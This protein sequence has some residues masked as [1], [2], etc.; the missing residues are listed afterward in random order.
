MDVDGDEDDELEEDGEEET[1]D[2][3]EF[4]TATCGTEET[5][6]IADEIGKEIAEMSE[7]VVSTA[8]ANM[9]SSA[10]LGMLVPIG[11]SGCAPPSKSVTKPREE[12]ISPGG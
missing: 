8:I 11:T 1:E 9:S 4:T 2:A 7:A 10:S 5:I 6:E 12:E 3:G